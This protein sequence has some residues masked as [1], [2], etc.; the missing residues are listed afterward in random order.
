[1][2]NYV[3]IKNKDALS[4]VQQAFEGLTVRSVDISE[5]RKGN[6]VTFKD[7]YWVHRLRDYVEAERNEIAFDL[8]VVGMSEEEK[9]SATKLVASLDR[10]ATELAKMSHEFRVRGDYQTT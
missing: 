5:N 9:E 6:V 4:I 1:M 2:R 3:F 8:A 10:I 7:S